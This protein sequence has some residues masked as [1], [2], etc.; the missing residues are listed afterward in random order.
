M[1]DLMQ[2]N[3]GKENAVH[4]GPV[5]VKHGTLD[6]HA[7][8]LVKAGAQTLR[9]H[10]SA[11]S[12]SSS[13]SSSLFSP[14]AVNVNKHLTTAS[15]AAKFLKACL[16]L[17]KIEN[18]TNRCAGCSRFPHRP[19]SASSYCK[20][21]QDMQQYGEPE[22]C[23]RLC[24]RFPYSKGG[25][26]DSCQSKEVLKGKYMPWV[27]DP[28]KDN[29]LSSPSEMKIAS[30]SAPQNLLSQHFA[31][32]TPLWLHANL[33]VAALD[34]AKQSFT[35]QGWLDFAWKDGELPQ[36]MDV[37]G[38]LK[39]DMLTNHSPPIHPHYM[40]KDGTNTKIQPA[41]SFKYDARTQV[42]QWSLSFVAT[43]PV[44]LE[45]SRF[46]FDRQFITIFALVRTK[47]YK[48]LH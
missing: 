14:S 26:C 9:D 22:K 29:G 39:W 6:E 31:D 13:S 25:P 47:K 19:A 46:P 34:V 20:T 30:P 2:H 15:S 24:D 43:L 37:T 5:S 3:E 1:Q 35:I 32:R 12:S 38:D 11:S 8:H 27:N 44:T 36:K 4:A 41:S 10:M 23:C 21:C 33:E 42:V 18:E 7:V 40:F 16:A 45:L 17:D 28:G 48:L